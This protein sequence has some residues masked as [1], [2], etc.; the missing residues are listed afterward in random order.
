MSKYVD[1]IIKAGTGTYQMGTDENGKPEYEHLEPDDFRSAA[2]AVTDSFME[3]V[4]AL[5]DGL[6]KLSWA[7]T[8]AIEALD[9]NMKPIMEAVGTFV[10]AIIKVATMNIIVG[11]DE[12]GK[13]IYEKL[14]IEEFDNAATV[15]VN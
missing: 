15:I 9:D 4:K 8:Y 6:G 7:Q 2:T 5:G 10:D 1:V 11:Y 3:F 12:K 13:P 14:D